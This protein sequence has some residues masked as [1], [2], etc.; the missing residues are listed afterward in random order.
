MVIKNIIT[1]N[2]IIKTLNSMGIGKGTML[3]VEWLY[4]DNEYI[5]GRE[6]TIIDALKECLG[7]EG[8]LIMPTF[9]FECLHP[10]HNKEIIERDNYENIKE[11]MR[12]YDKKLTRS[13]VYERIT[14][15]F[16]KNENVYRSDHPIYS[17]AS[18]GKKAKEIC[19]E[20]NYNF[21]LSSTS[22]LAKMCEENCY[23]LLMG[24]EL[25]NSYSLYLSNYAN[26]MIPIRLYNVGIHD[27]N[28]TLWKNILEIEFNNE[29]NDILK[30]MEERKTIYKYNFAGQEVLMYSIYEANK[31]CIEY[32]NSNYNAKL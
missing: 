20:H 31:T 28:K 32:F 13:N 14:N 18:W 27:K 8:T 7:K 12:G 19:E 10:V 22:P 2:D 3:Y 11:S 21:A 23:A 24:V 1:K 5:S 15:Q 30:I 17:F 29:Y 26:K 9:S 16:L 25:I 4:N 6:Q